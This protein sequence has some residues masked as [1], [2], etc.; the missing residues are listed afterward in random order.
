[1]N[2]HLELCKELQSLTK[3][4]AILMHSC[5]APCSSY[6]L[7]YLREYLKVTI[8]YYN[9]NITQIEEYQKRLTQQKNFIERFKRE[10]EEILLLE[11]QYNPEKFLAMSKGLEAEVEGGQRCQRCYELRLRETARVAKEQGFS[12]FST[13]LTISP[14]KNA[15]KL[16]EIGNE[17]AK[18]YGIS[19]LLS[20]FKKNNGYKRSIELSKEYDLYRQNY[21][22]C[23]YSQ[24]QS[25]SNQELK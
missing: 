16:N 13:T 24:Q 7:E 3:K 18:K 15:E 12:Y 6:V 4:E 2:Y 22:G 20:D 9:P 14:M 1:M 5:C 19:F 17:I 8:F 11:G 21:C 23:I 10:P 25:I